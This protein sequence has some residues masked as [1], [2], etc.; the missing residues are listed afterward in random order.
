VFDTQIAENTPDVAADLSRLSDSLDELAQADAGLAELVDLRFF[1]G[2][3]LPEIAALR[4][5][6]LRT[7]ERDWMKAKLYL[8]FQLD[9][10]HHQT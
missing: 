10:S 9:E 4:G 1:C 2:L 7:I 3:S 5:I 6:S 8:R